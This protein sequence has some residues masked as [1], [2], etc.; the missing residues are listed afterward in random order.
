MKLKYIIPILII[1]LS[2]IGCSTDD[3]DTPIVDE[4]QNLVKIQEIKNSDHTI[5]LYNKT[6]KFTTGYN[7][8]TIRIK[9]NTNDSYFENLSISW[10]P[11]M[12]MPAMQHSCP[13]SAITKITDKKTLYEGSVIYQMTNTNGSG[14]SLTF[15]YTIDNE[16]Y[17]ATD[18]ISVI[19]SEKQNVASFMGSDN[20]KYIV[21]LIEPKAPIIGINDLIIGLYK[22]ENMMSFPVVQDYRIMLDP[23]MPGMGN[24]S[25]PNNTDLS[26]DT[27]DNIYHGDLSLTMTGYWVLN[28]KLM[29]SDDSLLKGE[30]VTESNERSSLYLELEF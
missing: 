10:M 13:K 11:V 15:E 26:Y 27:T 29:D 7:N 12:K 6:G 5:E 24:H 17:T 22:M 23:R 28:L 9:D 19:Q 2:T 8:V 18:T 25:S 21:A 30:D 20:K 14:W 4:I 16:D 1:S 3:N